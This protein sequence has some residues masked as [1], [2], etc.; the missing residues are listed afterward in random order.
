MIG[1]NAG[2]SGI[3]FENV[4]I[5]STGL[6][7]YVDSRVIEPHEGKAIVVYTNVGEAE[8]NGLT[9]SNIESEDPIYVK[10][11]FG[12]KIRYAN[13]PLEDIRLDP[14]IIKLPRLRVD[15]ISV[16]PVPQYASNYSINWELADTNIAVIIDTNNVYASIMGKLPGSTYLIAQTPDGLIEDTCI[17][18]VVPAV[19]IY[20]PDQ[21]C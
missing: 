20:S 8:I 3:Y 12:L 7:P 16:N 10:K 13:I 21:F 18:D 2:F 1:G 14:K 6:D 19:N 5:D 9:I 11:G 4:I 17:V 15:T